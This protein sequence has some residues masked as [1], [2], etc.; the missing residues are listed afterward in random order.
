MPSATPA[1]KCWSETYGES[2]CAWVLLEA[3]APA[4]SATSAAAAAMRGM[5]AMPAT[6]GP[7]VAR[8]E[9]DSPT[10]VTAVTSGV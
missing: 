10:R 8:V 6:L 5:V 7:G 1:S 2:L 3:R 9:R 4:A